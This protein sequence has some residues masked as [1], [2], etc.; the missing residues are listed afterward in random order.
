MGNQFQT[1]LF[2]IDLDNTLIYTDRANNLAYEKAIK[3]IFPSRQGIT[4]FNEIKNSSPQRITKESLSNIP[5]FDK[6]TINHIT[7]LK[8]RY[9]DDFL[10]STISNQEKIDKKINDICKHNN[11][12]VS[13]SIKIM[14]TNCSNKR[15]NSILSYHNLTAY[16]SQIIYCN[17]IHNKFDFALSQLNELLNTYKIPHKHIFIFDDDIHQLNDIKQK[18]NISYINLVHIS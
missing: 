10:S 7:T 18:S 2:L 13:K 11:L 1:S 17:G 14:V 9:Y 4:L 3:D 12:P 8:E 15:A 6:N 5:Y 16:F